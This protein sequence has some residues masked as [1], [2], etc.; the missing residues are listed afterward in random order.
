MFTDIR[1]CIA[2]LSEKRN[3]WNGRYSK[4]PVKIHNIREYCI[5]NILPDIS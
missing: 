2:N 5:R 1:Y 4:N 3:G